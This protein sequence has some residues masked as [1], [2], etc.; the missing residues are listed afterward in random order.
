[1]VAI[2]RPRTTPAGIPV[3]PGLPL[4]GNLLDFRKNRLVMQDKAAR[5]A[6]LTRVN[7]IDL[8]LFSVSD[9]DLV[10]EIL[11]T[12]AEHFGKGA[13]TSKFL[14]PLLGAGLLT[15]EG[16]LHKQHRKLLA[17]A[18]APRR[19]QAYGTSMVAE[20]LEA[21]ATWRDGDV[22]DVLPQMMGLTLTIAGRTL[23]NADVRRDAALVDRGLTMAMEAVQTALTSPL[24]VPYDVPLPR[25]RRLRKAVGM[26]DAVVYRLIRERRA[27]GVDQGDVMSML[28]LTRGDDG[29]AFTDQQ[30]RDEVMTMIL[31]GHETTANALAWTLYELG[32]HPT[33]RA[34]V[35][36]EVDA[37]LA[38]RPP[39][40]DDLPQL[41]YTLQVL[42]ESLR[43]HPPVWITSREALRDVTLGG[44]T[45]AA[46]T[47]FTL[48]IRG[49]H[50]RHDYYPDPE[51]FRPERMTAA[52]KKARPRHRYLP[53]GAGPRVCIGAHFALME[54][55][56]ILA[57][58]AQRVSLRPT[59]ALAVPPDP[60]LT[61]RPSTDL[62]MAVRRR[63][64]QA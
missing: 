31:A 17:P 12:Q 21:L 27:S 39:T 13:S 37:V 19:V 28:L 47:I 1:M 44:H 29:A 61:L 32:R 24:Q 25:H 23:F 8:P 46:N 15:A 35:E 60:L 50:R 59:S 52:E 26:L 48:N 53:F 30:I 55:H 57:T 7:L 45:F 63:G 42:E 3:L 40:V 56:L 34:A 10:H 2:P 51:A 14:E 22:V 4:I 62:P 33:I 58:L 16:E 54:A 6:P 38:G 64:A 41:P 5:L 11:V 18:F 49:I 36:A 20:T 9:A 43:L